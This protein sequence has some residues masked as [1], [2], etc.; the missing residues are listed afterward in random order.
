MNLREAMALN[1]ADFA[2]WAAE[3]NKEYRARMIAEGMVYFPAIDRWYPA[4]TEIAGV[5]AEE[6]A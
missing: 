3:R 1:N 5:D 6:S 4:G 2:V